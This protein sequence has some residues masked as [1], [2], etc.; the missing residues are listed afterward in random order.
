MKKSRIVCVLMSLILFVATLV[1]CGETPEKVMVYDTNTKAQSFS[2]R[3]VAQN[4]KYKLEWNDDVKCV[5]LYSLETGK[6]WSN[7]PYE[8][9]MSG[10]SSA[11]VNSTINITIVNSANLAWDTIRGSSAAVEDGRVFCKQIKNGVRITYCFDNYKIS[12]PVEY[13]LRDDSLKVTV[14]SKSII[15]G[16]DYKLAAVSLA[17]FLC[18]VANS[19]E[20]A[21]LFIPSGSGAIMLAEEDADGRRRYTGEVYGTDASRRLPE[22]LVDEEVIRLPVFGVADGNNAL[23]GIIEEGAP[24]A[25]IS[26]EA[27]NPRTG[28]SNVYADFYLRGYDIF[29]T[30]YSAFKNEDLTRISNFRSE[31]PVTVGFYPLS[32]EEANYNGMAKLYRKYLQDKGDLSED[33]KQQQLYSLTLLGGIQT[34]ENYMGIKK[35]T[36]KPMT[37]FAQAEDIITQIT[38]KTGLKPL[39]RLLG[40]GDGGINTGSV[41]GGFGFSSILEDSKQDE[42]EQYCKENKIP[43]FTDFDLIKYSKSG[44]GFSY[45]S[46]AAETALKFIAE[47]YPIKIPSREYNMDLEYRL[48]KRELLEKVL[49]KV[50]KFAD[51]NDISG[52]SFSSLGSMAYSDYSDEM[53]AVKGNTEEDAKKLISESKKAGHNVAVA[54][55]NGYAACAADA[56]LDI[57]ISNGGNFAFDKEIPFYQMVFRGYKP[58]YSTA[59]NLSEEPRKQL[60]LS[61]MSG[62]GI[63]FTLINNFE[64]EYTET[65]SGKIY[66]AVYKD[67]LSGILEILKNESEY[68]RCFK[69]I[70][71]SSIASYELLDNNISKTVFTNGVV[72]YANHSGK[73]VQ[74]EFGDFNAY[75]FKTEEKGVLN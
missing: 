43:L 61:A 19:T 75:E 4:E 14:D 1:G 24:S 39:V 38:D 35:K 31:K 42:L 36:V 50:I 74:T 44:S 67:N 66:G 5:M 58:I 34:T 46:S 40:F 52:L 62:T 51:K 73:S 63:S 21:Y 47:Q 7:I 54:N 33:T 8:Y 65:A 68:V 64:M 56:V 59:Q 29:A 11:N 9:Y 25:V 70:K 27:G 16:G 53:Y 72:V 10:G 71:D 49:G 12:V 26:A 32:G 6:I 28:Y 23:L 22:I 17:P 18:S 41:A 57:P 55:A 3:T 30:E 20:N 60:M 15:E 2:S 45:S 37:T 13:V 48:L 69:A